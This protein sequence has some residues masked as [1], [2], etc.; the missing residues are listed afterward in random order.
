M[1]KSFRYD[2]VV[3]GAGPNG[4]AAAITLARSG[5]SVLVIEGHAQVGGGT[6]TAELTL[7]GFQQ[8]VCSAI[9][10]LGLASPF[11]RELPLAQFGLEWVHPPTPLAHVLD[12]GQAGVLEES[13]EATCARLGGD[14]PAYRRLMMPLVRGWQGVLHDLLGPLPLPPRHPL[15]DL[16]MGL[17][18]LM[19]ARSLAQILF[20]GEAAQGLFAGMAG[21]A[22]LPLERPLT[23]AVGLMLGLLGHAVGWPMAKGGSQRITEAMTAFLLSLGGEVITG[24][25]VKSLDELPTSRAVL[26]DVTPC[27]LIALAGDRLSTG[28]RR[29]LER[30][31][32]GQGVFK[33]DWALDGPIPWRSE[34]AHR[35]E[36][37]GA[38]NTQRNPSCCWRS[39]ACST[40]AAPRQVSILP[41]HT[42][43]CRAARRWI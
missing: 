40:R 30:Y 12:D 27:Q 15:L 14:G 35:K 38:A 32:Y 25:W 2:A 37:F 10:P 7:P 13:L 16:Q 20:K 21:H 29:Q 41:G 17:P 18:G 5:L 36:Q 33:V 31:R 19:P 34:A 3:V 39:K 23:S 42:A 9:H 1:V 4:L 26:L 43:T 8:D 11:F 28:Y 22:M 6:R 24:Q